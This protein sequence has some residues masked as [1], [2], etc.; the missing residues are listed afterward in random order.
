MK[1]ND[2]T[3]DCQAA[4]QDADTRLVEFRSSAIDRSGGF[5]RVNIAAGL[6]ILEYVGE[7]ISKAE[8]LC[9]CE[10]NNEYIFT[11][12]DEFDLDG[13]VSWNPARLL[14]HSCTPN[15]EAELDED[16]IWIVSLRDIPAGEELTFNYG[17]DLDNYREHPCRC[18]ASDCV[19][20]I[21]A[22]EFFEHLRRQRTLAQV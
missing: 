19:G 6:R 15:C 11:L 21:V 22:E 5:A 4:P 7:R 10:A 2:E 1:P 9:R 12:N 14:N 18:G 17:Y 8:S 16:R 3:M 20:Y 13:N